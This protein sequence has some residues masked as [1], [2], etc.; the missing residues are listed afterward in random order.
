[1][2][3]IAPVIGTTGEEPKVETYRQRSICKVYPREVS[4]R[5][6]WVRDLALPKCCSCEQGAVQECRFKGF[7][8]LVL[9]DPPSIIFGCELTAASEEPQYPYVFT[10]MHDC[11]LIEWKKD[12]LRSALQPILN[13]AL[14][15]ES[16]ESARLIRRVRDVQFHD[17]CDF[18]ATTLFSCAWFCQSCGREYCEACWKDQGCNLICCE[19]TNDS[20]L[21]VTRF[22]EGELRALLGDMN[23]LEVVNPRLDLGNDPQSPLYIPSNEL[24]DSLL[25]AYLQAG[26]P[27]IAHHATSKLQALW[28]PSGFMKMFGS[29]KCTV[30]DCESEH[31]MKTTISEFF[32]NFGHAR[33]VGEFASPGTIWKLKVDWPPTEEFRHCAPELFD[34]YL[35]AS[36]VPSF[37]NPNGAFNLAAHIPRNAIR[38]DLGPKMYNAFAS[39]QDEDHHGSTRLHIDICEAV[40]YLT[41]AVIPT[42]NEAELKPEN[43]AANWVIV[44]RDDTERLVEY[45]ERTHRSSFS[46]GDNPI[47]IQKCFLTPSNVDEII[48]LGIRAYTI[49]QSIGDAVFIPAGCP[50]Q[51]SNTSDAMKVACDFLSPAAIGTCQK[52]ASD[53]RQ[54]RIKYGWPADVLQLENLLYFAYCSLNVLW[55][56]IERNKTEGLSQASF[57]S[58]ELALPSDKTLDVHK[59]RKA[60]AKAKKM[61]KK[62][63]K[64][65]DRPYSCPAEGTVCAPGMKF[66]AQGLLDHMSS[67]AVVIVGQPEQ[68]EEYER[69]FDETRG[70]ASRVL[71]VGIDSRQSALA[72]PVYLQQSTEIIAPCILINKAVNRDVEEYRRQVHQPSRTG[73]SHAARGLYLAYH[74][75]LPKER[76]CTHNSAPS[77]LPK[78]DCDTTATPTGC[79]S[80]R[81]AITV[82]ERVRTKPMSQVDARID[83]KRNEDQNSVP[84]K[85]S[86]SG[87]HLHYPEYEPLSTDQ[88]CQRELVG[89]HLEDVARSSSPVRSRLPR[90]FS[91]PLTQRKKADPK[92]DFGN[93]LLGVV[94]ISAFAH[95]P[96]TRQTE[97]SIR[98][99][100]QRRRSNQLYPSGRRT[101]SY[102]P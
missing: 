58:W 59:W 50:H 46:D 21:P 14:D 79:T 97:H 9:K 56:G 25:Y 98:R 67:F 22:A 30:Q 78:E 74:C 17:V 80:G 44:H 26:I 35:Q 85:P 7:R 92:L 69:D 82:A 45:L 32:L 47:L 63:A 31:E 8:I 90:P 84:C 40:N 37:T 72:G 33:R 42:T 27:V 10:I 6:D 68:G 61:R 86:R 87:R 75:T 3:N 11:Q 100:P 62:V 91:Q 99:S 12:I 51:V 19:G 2:T 24:T 49:C 76:T 5:Y 96:P 29:Q 64:V 73:A 95:V 43:G 20:L 52:L 23:K 53:F 48:R 71:S 102:I 38:P 101:F 34:D 55:K 39:P 94:R 18:C 77:P 4:K 28:N 15:F 70:N 88:K 81:C 83:K 41:Y 13:N 54:Q 1:M 93:L 66:I 36:L 16:R 89:Y 65:Q 57:P 60:L